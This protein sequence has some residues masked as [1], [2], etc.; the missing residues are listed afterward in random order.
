M[1][2][3]VIAEE[4]EKEYYEKNNIDNY[5][6]TNNIVNYINENRVRS[7][8]EI[9][10]GTGY[11]LNKV[12]E[13][14]KDLNRIIGIDSSEEMLNIAIRKYTPKANIEFRNIDFNSLKLANCHF[15][16]I[17]TNFF[18]SIFKNDCTLENNLKKVYEMLS[19]NGILN[20]VENRIPKSKSEKEVCFIEL[21][22]SWCG[23]KYKFEYQLYNSDYFIKTMRI[24]GF[25]EIIRI[26][27]SED[28]YQIKGKK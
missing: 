22:E 19:E 25:R 17:I 15:D 5:K 9:G 8:L 28:I 23:G 3:S 18:W 12:F 16:F 1:H 4:Y 7:V 20:I 21:N 27:I 11:W 26:D 2:Y 6:I 13:N 24:V 14:C 10:C